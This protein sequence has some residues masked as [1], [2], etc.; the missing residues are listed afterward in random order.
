MTK[1]D[2]KKTYSKLYTPSAKTFS[3]VDVPAI[4]FLMIDGKGNPNTSTEYQEAVGALYGAAYHIKF[5]LKAQGM[6]YIVPPMEGLWWAKDM[7]AFTAGNKDEWFWTM[8]I[9]QPEEVTPEILVHTKAE[10][11]KKKGPPALE[12]VRLE[13]FHEGLC[14]QILYFGP[15]ADEGPTI[16]GLHAFITENGYTL[17]GKHHEIYLGDPRKTA[18]EKLKTVIRQPMQKRNE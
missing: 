13:H 4:N 11:A 6:D 5:W 10:L 15:Y 17:S 2:F 16:A 12:S 8:M 1:I 3:I 14:A 9:L 18:P 7:S